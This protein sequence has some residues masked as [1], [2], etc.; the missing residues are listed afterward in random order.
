[1]IKKVWLL[2]L[3][4]LVLSTASFAQTISYQVSEAEKGGSV[5]D[6]SVRTKN[7]F[8]VLKTDRSRGFM[9]TKT[10]VETTL[11][12]VDNDLN[13]L[14]EIPFA[15]PDADYIGIKGLQRLGDKCYFFYNKRKKKSDE[16]SFCGMMIDETDIRKSKEI[17]MG[18]F[19][20]EKGEP[21]FKLQVAL[22]ST[23]VMLFVEPEQKKNDNKNF[24]FALFDNNLSKLWD[25]N[26]ELAIESKYIDLF[27]YASKQQDQVFVSYKHYDQEIKR[28]SV[29]NGDGSRIPSY[30]TNILSFKKGESKPK[31]IH[32]NLGGKFV[33]S[34][35]IIFNHKTGKIC[36]LGMYKNK[37]NGHVNGVYYSELNPETNE[38]LNTKSTAFTQ[39]LVELVKKD[40]FASKKESDPGLSISYVGLDPVIRDNGSVDYLM[41]YRLLEIITRMV[42]KTYYSFPRY[43]YGT[44]VDAHFDN[45]KV[46]FTRVPKYQQ[47]DN[48]NTL[49]SFYPYLYQNKLILLYNDDKDNA[50]KDLSKSP[51]AISNFKRAVLMAASIDDNNNMSRDIIM[52]VKSSDDFITNMKLVQKIDNNTLIFTQ[53]KMKAMS[54]KTRYGTMTIK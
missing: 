18:S 6:Y 44:I 14:Q 52:D 13:V 30:K 4:A 36:M 54:S 43:T 7:G 35:D 34:N 46:A 11:L 9:S 29:S 10:T 39:E 50:E 41:E 8:L 17:V 15:V 21:S 45:G 28:E 5:F 49:L 20:S 53:N 48:D 19:I 32:L 12:L 33:H 51:D 42:G 2:S 31:E 38:L 26:V 27:G 24:Y 47:E 22:D 1:M 3:V 40:R 37:Y 25:N 23:A 16:I